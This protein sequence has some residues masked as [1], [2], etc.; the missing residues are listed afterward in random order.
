MFTVILTLGHLVLTGVAV[1]PRGHVVMISDEDV[2][3][4]SCINYV[5]KRSLFNQ[6]L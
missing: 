1:S 3:Y 6:V 4:L 5:Y 2:V